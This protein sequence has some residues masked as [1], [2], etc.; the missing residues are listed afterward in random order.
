M[1][2]LQHCEVVEP[3]TNTQAYGVAVVPL[4]LVP[5]ACPEHQKKPGISA[6]LR[7][8]SEARTIGTYVLRTRLQSPA[9]DHSRGRYSSANMRAHFWG[10]N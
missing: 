1:G 4:P 2:K 6:G 8:G 5:R 10:R 3:L 7:E 9:T